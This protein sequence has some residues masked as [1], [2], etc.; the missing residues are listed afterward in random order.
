[1]YP[2]SYE[3]VKAECEQRMVGDHLSY[4]HSGMFSISKDKV[5][6]HRKYLGHVK[7]QSQPYLCFLF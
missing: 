5:F 1:M 2:S 7:E 6:K 4:L 3:K